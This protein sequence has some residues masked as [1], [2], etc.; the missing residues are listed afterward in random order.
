MI[1]EVLPLLRHVPLLLALAGSAAAGA[2]QDPAGTRCEFGARGAFKSSSGDRIEISTQGVVFQS[3][4][5]RAHLTVKTNHQVAQVRIA[6]PS[7]LDFYS[8]IVSLYP[9]VFENVRFPA[10]IM[11]IRKRNH[12]VGLLPVPGG[13]L[14]VE[15]SDHDPPT[16]QVF[17]S[18]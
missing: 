10:C 13:I 15:V 9:R 12:R 14:F 3:S 4:T 5:S 18:K 7:A 8:D 17:L 2:G 11:Q 6:D 16:T 1:S